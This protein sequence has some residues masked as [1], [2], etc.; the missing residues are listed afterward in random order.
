MRKIFAL[1]LL[2]A[3]A[4]GVYSANLAIPAGQVGDGR[5][6]FGASY[7]YVG[8]DITDDEVPLTMN[9]VIAH[10]SY[11]PV[12][13]VNFGVDLGTARV[14]VDA[15]GILP[16]FEGNYGY[17]VGAHL[18]LATPY[19]GNCV[20]ILGVANGNFFRSKND[21]DAFYGGLDAAAALG[22]QFRIPNGAITIGPQLYLIQGENKGID[23]TTADYTNVNNAKVWLTYDYIPDYLAF[24]G[25]HKPYVSI[26]F[27]ASPKFDS[28]A[29]KVS[30]SGFSVSLS[31][32]AIGMDKTR[33][34]PKYTQ[35]YIELKELEQEVADEL[36][37][38]YDKGKGKKRKNKCETDGEKSEEER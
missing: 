33:R 9:N 20:S 28:D 21:N 1:S 34:R 25:D 22:I 26:E 13:Y 14:D 19:F 8:A 36:K 32:G 16:A 23:G 5:V 7:V 12:R 31:V 6:S 11:A 24:G 15:A 27:A 30:I 3:S 37:G 10:V 4:V 29:G 18:K 2:F 17:S 38:E 35:S